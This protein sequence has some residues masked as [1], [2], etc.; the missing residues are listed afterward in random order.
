MANFSGYPSISI[1][2]YTKGE[3]HWGINLNG[4][5][6]G[7]QDLLDVAATIEELFNC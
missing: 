5:N 6:L 1:P 7:D 4:K 2:F 3:Q